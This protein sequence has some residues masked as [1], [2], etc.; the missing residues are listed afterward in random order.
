M[1]EPIL[2]Q[3]TMPCLCLCLRVLFDRIAFIFKLSN[4]RH[5]PHHESTVQVLVLVLR[6]A[7]PTIKRSPTIKL[8]RSQSPPI[9]VYRLCSCSRT[10][11][12]EP[13]E[14]TCI[15]LCEGEQEQCCFSNIKSYH[16]LNQLT[17]DSF[18]TRLAC[19]LLPSTDHD[20]L[21]SL[22]T[23]RTPTQNYKAS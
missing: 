18:E 16:P 10:A 6:L 13:T 9:Q 5:T 14:C 3:N 7:T 8:K 17:P 4:C 20:K 11:C 19:I 15:Y 12:S 21:L 22:S 1:K 2:A 23:G